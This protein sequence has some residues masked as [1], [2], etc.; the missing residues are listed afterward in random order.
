MTTLSG[1][2]IDYSL[3]GSPKNSDGIVAMAAENEHSRYIKKLRL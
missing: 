1:R 3:R 2:E